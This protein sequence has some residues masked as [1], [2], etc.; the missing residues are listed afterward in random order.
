MVPGFKISHEPVLRS[1]NPGPNNPRI[2]RGTFMADPEKL[3]GFKVLKEASLISPHPFAPDGPL[4][5]TLFRVLAA[6]EIN[7][8]FVTCL[9][10]KGGRW[11]INMV[12]DF[13]DLNAASR[14]LAEILP[15]SPEKISGTAVLSVFPHR[16]KPAITGALFEAF[17]REG[18][19]PKAITHSPSAIS[20]VIRE[21]HLL[22][23]SSALFGPF[24]FGAYRTP[25]DW[26]LAQKG[27]EKRYKE[28]VASYQEKRPKVYG[29]EYQDRQEL[30]R[31]RLEASRMESLGPAFKA[32]SLKKLEFTFLA[33]TRLQ[34]KMNAVSLCLPLTRKGSTG[35][36]IALNV[37]TSGIE[38]DVPVGTFSM[39]GPHFGDRYGIIRDL[40]TALET[41]GIDLLGLSCTIASITGV[42]PSSQLSRTIDAIRNCFDV[43]SVLRRDQEYG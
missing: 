6:H 38:R 13:K 42:V 23:A 20:A 7:L 5:V 36:S 35:A 37:G 9:P 19:H 43:P 41:A 15:Q 40:L 28:V 24:A 12:V 21:D 29:L 32:A 18:I 14:L 16:K 33:V 3:G 26:K 17:S 1:L 11:R 10:E 25:A 22:Q 39:N 34:E 8:S 30:L 31:M 4:P 27:K 2:F